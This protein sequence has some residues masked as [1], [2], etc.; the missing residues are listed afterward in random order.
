MKKR[1][2]TLVLAS[3]MLSAAKSADRLPN[4]VMIVADDLGYGDLECYGAKNVSTPAVN[5]LAQSGIRFTDVHAVAATSTPSRYSL[6]TGE[7]P[8]RRPGTDV[9]PGNAGMIIRPEQFTIADMFRSNGYATAAIGKWHLGLGDKTGTQD[10]NAPLAASP[11]DLGFDYHYIMAATSDRVPCVFIEQGFV[12]NYDPTDSIFVSYRQNFEGEPTGK[13]NPELLYNLKHSHGHDQSIVNGIGR[14]GYMKG[15]GKARWKDENIADSITA[16]AVD[17]IESHKDEPF[18]MYFATNDVHVPRFPHER[19]RGKNPMG[20]RGDAIVQ[21]DWSVEQ[22]MNALEKAGV[23]DNTIVILTS[24]NGPVLDDG[25]D[26][27][28]EELLNG[29]RPTGPFRGNKYSAF[30]G[31]TA[32]PFIVS[33]KGH[34]APN[35]E[36]D[37]LVSHI[38]IMRS[39]G[40]LFNARLPKESACDSRDNLATILGENKTSRE[41]LTEMSNTHVLSVRSGKWKYIEPSNGPAMIQWG[42]KVETGNLAEP[43]LYDMSVDQGERK[44]VASEHPDVVAKMQ[45]YIEEVRAKK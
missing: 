43:Q 38:D 14:I 31:G 12:A 26:D 11:A 17:F 21:F 1:I 41:Y 22:I 44:N 42:P 27:K 4:V 24:D 45:A 29:H 28:A 15:G 18:F 20:L 3:F 10:W 8:W 19:F 5:K 39:L 40:S 37:A 34:I 36:S 32:V 30:E 33:W 7:Y 13:N 23:L 35:Q 2:L 6:L 16:K 25:Y 9:A